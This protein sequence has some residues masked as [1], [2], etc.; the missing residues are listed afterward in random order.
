VTTSKKEQEN[1]RR[2]GS[3]LVSDGREERIGRGR[4]GEGDGRVLGDHK[5]RGHCG[6]CSLEERK[7][8]EKRMPHG[9]CQKK[10]PSTRERSLARHWE[11]KK[12]PR[13]AQE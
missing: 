4:G 1:G 10:G 2:A 12:T 3:K 5:R 8:R 11:E 9:Y 6:D 13:S 7:V